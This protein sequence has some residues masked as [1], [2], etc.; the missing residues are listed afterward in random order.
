MLNIQF[1]LH[2]IYQKNCN[3]FTICCNHTQIGY[4]I[5]NYSACL[6]FKFSEW[7]RKTIGHLFYAM[8]SFVHYF[9]AINKFQL[10]LQL[11]T[12]NLGQI[13]DLLCP[14]WPWIFMDDLE[15]Y[16]GTPSMLLQACVSFYGHRSIHT[17]VTVRRKH[18]IWGKIGDCFCPVWPW[19]LMDDLHK[20]MAP[21]PCCSKLFV[22]FHSHRW[23]HTGVT[24]RKHSI[25]VK[26]SDLLSCVTWKFDRW[27]WKTIGHLFFTTP[28][29]MHQFRS[30]WWIQTGVTVRKRPNWVE[31]N[32]LFLAAWCRNLTDY[33]EKQ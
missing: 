26:I 27:P 12:P 8:S 24:V 5:V 29:F 20:N 18:S 21:L 31:I 28:S 30:H 25:W 16:Y 7:P 22:S 13:G 19:N 1:S 17:G 33:L 23:I 4:K 15:K 2:N 14:V 32:D 9:K 6:P 3:V 10:E 11:E